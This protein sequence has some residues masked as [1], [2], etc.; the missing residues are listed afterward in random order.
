MIQET[1]QELVVIESLDVP[2]MFQPNGLDVIIDEIEAKA[3]DFVSD[4][5]TEAGR[6][7]VASF[8]FK[9]ARSKKL[10]EKLGKDCASEAEKTVK[11][12]RAERMRGVARLQEIQDQIRQPLDEY[13]QRERDRIQ[14]HEK[15]ILQIEILLKFNDFDP[16]AEEIKT[17]LD[18]LGEFLS[19]DW[20]E[21]HG[22]ANKLISEVTGTLNAR[23]DSR[24][25]WEEDQKQLARLKKL[26]EEQKQKE[27]DE[28]IAKKAAEEAKLA[29][30]EKARKEKEVIEKKAQQEADAAKQREFQLQQE[31]EAVEQA[32]KEAE[33]KAAAEKQKIE[34]EKYAAERLAEERKRISIV[35]EKK[36]KAD[37][38]LAEKRA[39]EEKE[40]AVI[41]ER[42]RLEAEQEIIEKEKQVEEDKDAKRQ[43]NKRHR[44]KIED[45]SIYSL[46]DYMEKDVATKFI[47]EVKD[48]NIKNIS[49]NY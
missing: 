7:E 40:E 43:A 10:V 32:K 48:G 30:E 49:I 31:K 25:K 8:A 37:A 36:A 9:I 21:F 28:A 39:K 46:R 45:Q 11:N 27:H 14:A 15:A 34:Q 44:K 24:L 5:S 19:V 16:T 6:K 12:I 1:E 35:A 17:N 23:L 33:E 13:E 3:N 38:K 41:A 42:E 2:K 47:K 29:A 4:I 18:K 20:Q 26:E 22:R